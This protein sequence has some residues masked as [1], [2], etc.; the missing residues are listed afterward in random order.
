MTNV[1]ISATEASRTF[2]DVLNKVYYQNTT[3]EIKRGKDVVATLTPHKKT[4][5]K[6]TL[7]AKDLKNFLANLPA[8][9]AAD[10]VAFEKDIHQL[11]AQNQLGKTVWD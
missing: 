6:P 9:N 4:I 7:A 3:F 11:R 10:S 5:N 8:L 1:I 2:S